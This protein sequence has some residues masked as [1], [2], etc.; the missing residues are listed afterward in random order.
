MK[1]FNNLASIVTLG[2]L[3]ASSLGSASP[4]PSPEIAVENLD[5]LRAINQN[6]PISLRTDE[7][8]NSE[9]TVAPPNIERGGLHLE[10]FS[11]LLGRAEEE[12]AMGRH[13]RPKPWRPHRR[14]HKKPA[15]K[16]SETPSPPEPA[17]ETGD[18]G[19][20]QL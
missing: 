10:T 6:G 2:V 14:P 4:S 16:P 9:D 12:A 20:V 13:R 18:A 17:P 8:E 19:Y 1:S 7:D 11:D 5:G 15:M 3:L